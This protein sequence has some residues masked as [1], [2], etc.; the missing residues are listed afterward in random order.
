MTYF[1]FPPPGIYSSN[2]DETFNITVIY[3]D[4]FVI[5]FNCVYYKSAAVT[6][7]LKVI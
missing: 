1:N 6:T 7:Y 3:T 4:R 2:D 5:I